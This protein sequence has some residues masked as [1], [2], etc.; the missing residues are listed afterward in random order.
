MSVDKTVANLAKTIDY[1]DELDVRL[2]KRTEQFTGQP[3]PSQITQNSVTNKKSIMWQIRDIPDKYRLPDLVMNVNPTN[4]KT[5]YKQLINRRRTIGGFL[6]QHWGEELDSMSMSGITSNFYG[7]LGLTNLKRRDTD[8]FREFEKFVQIYRNNGSLYDEKTSMIVAQ[9]SIIM[10]Y[11]SCIYS[12]YFESFNINETI[13]KNF[14]LQYDLSFKVT[15]E[16]FPGKRNTFS[17]V[18]TVLRPG[19]SKNDVVTLDIT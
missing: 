4:L 16:L 2:R 12:G 11:D 10:S 1:I 14:N 15:K 18:T 19:S 6:E 13:D 8:S 3:F 9:G 17:N 5:S 7:P